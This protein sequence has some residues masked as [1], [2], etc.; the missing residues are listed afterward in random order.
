VL[1][2]SDSNLNWTLVN[3]FN[4]PPKFKIAWKSI[5]HFMDCYMSPERDR[6]THGENGCIIIVAL[7]GIYF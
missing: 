7:G 6:Q 1:F 3:N 4:E 5:Q 2:I